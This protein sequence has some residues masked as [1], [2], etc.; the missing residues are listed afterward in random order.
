[1]TP[2]AGKWVGYGVGTVGLLLLA[3]GVG[4]QG[5]ATGG[6]AVL[7]VIIAIGGAICAGIYWRCP[8]CGWFLPT[9]TF[10]V[11]HCHRCGES[12]DQPIFKK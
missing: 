8:S 1:M 11:E 2:R 4:S 5:S 10:F 7:G 12:I 6:L 3:A 9:R